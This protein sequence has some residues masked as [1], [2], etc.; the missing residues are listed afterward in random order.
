M[1]TRRLYAYLLHT[2]AIHGTSVIMPLSIFTFTIMTFARHQYR[3][4]LRPYPVLRRFVPPPPIRSSKEVGDS[5][6]GDARFLSVTE[7]SACYKSDLRLK[8]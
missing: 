4:P 7:E 3:L 6:R 2:K 5:S 1:S 8:R